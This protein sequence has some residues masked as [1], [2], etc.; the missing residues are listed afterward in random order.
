MV[1]ESV[2]ALLSNFFFYH[3]EIIA[4]AVLGF[5]GKW[6]ISVFWLNSRANIYAQK[7]CS[8]QH[9]YKYIT[10]KNFLLLQELY[11]VRQLCYFV[12]DIAYFCVY[13]SFYVYV[14]VLISMW[15]YPHIS[16]IYYPNNLC[17]FIY[18]S[19]FI[20]NIYF[21]VTREH[22]QTVLMVPHNSSWIIFTLLSTRYFL[23]RK[24][25]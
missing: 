8:P 6:Q 19:K 21:S 14:D 12:L 5:R 20:I 17:F 10:Y 18:V 25:N 1:I 9:F 15:N 7:V 2:F 22:I 4:H 3:T 16:F 13:A 23:Q 24:C 11:V